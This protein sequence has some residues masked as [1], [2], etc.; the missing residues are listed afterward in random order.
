MARKVQQG[1]SVQ[2]SRVSYYSSPAKGQV[3][4]SGG[5][6][7]G[8]NRG[9]LYQVRTPGGQMLSGRV[10]ARTYHRIV[11]AEFVGTVLVIGL[12]PIL[13][14]NTKSTTAET[15][16]VIASLTFAGPLIRLTAACIVFFLLALLA[17]GEKTGK[18]A[19]AAGGLILAGAVLNA[20][21]TWG[22]LAKA[23]SSGGSGGASAAAAAR[24][25]PDQTT[26][27]TSLQITPGGS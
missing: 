9:G 19:A 22:A 18:V 2:T 4:T 12:A 10:P 7:Y 3:L 24:P 5:Y 16:E 20:T 21:D 25:A 1:S 8:R 13:V 17:A 11:L 6:Q 27:V 14:P 23:F 26:G 15:G